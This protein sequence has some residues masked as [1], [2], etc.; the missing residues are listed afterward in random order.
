MK[1]RILCVFFALCICI[2]C[3]F[4]VP[5][6][7]VCNSLWD[8]YSPSSMVEL[9]LSDYVSL[10]ADFLRPQSPYE[11]DFLYALTSFASDAY[12]AVGVTDFFILY[13]DTFYKLSLSGNDHFVLYKA[14]D[15]S[16][17]LPEDAPAL[18]FFSLCAASTF[19]DG[20]DDDFRLMLE[21]GDFSSFFSEG[22]F[23]ALSSSYQ[24]GYFFEPFFLD[25]QNLLVYFPSDR[26][27]SEPLVCCA[28]PCDQD[29][30]SLTVSKIVEAPASE[31][32]SFLSIFL[33][34]GQWLVSLVSVLIALFYTPETGLTFVGVLAVAGLAFSVAFLLIKLIKGWLGFR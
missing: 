10:E 8:Y 9:G 32:F 26:V 12:S 16:S 11:Q 28:I 30:S 33:S 25:D 31:A 4:C 20:S 14:L 34:V 3:F 19:F 5:C 27:G 1:C 13:P 2:S 6:Y 21:S 29:L 24:K 7:A 15:S 22:L 18:L 17:D 23:F